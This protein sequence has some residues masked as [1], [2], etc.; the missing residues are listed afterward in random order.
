MLRNLV[1]AVPYRL[2]AEGNMIGIGYASEPEKV[3]LV[4]EIEVYCR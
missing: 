1:V 3:Q 2:N 4:P